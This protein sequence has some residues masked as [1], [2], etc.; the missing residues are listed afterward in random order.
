MKTKTMI[1][2]TA[3]VPF[4][5]FEINEALLFGAIII[6]AALL[7]FFLR[8]KNK[9][10]IA[11]D[12][13]GVMTTGDYLTGPFNPRKNMKQLVKNLRKK[14]KVIALTNDNT[15]AYPAISKHLGMDDV[16]E[17]QF[18][19]SEIGASKPDKRAFVFLLNK[20]GLKPQELVFID[21]KAENVASAKSMGIRGFQFTSLEKL[22]ADLRSINITI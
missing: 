1:S 15:I 13:G 14:Y 6:V 3:L 12:V 20:F 2:L 18:V 7:V 10:V 11:F 5:I 22:V 8:N 19:S 4:G 9:T 21:D 17:R 16:F